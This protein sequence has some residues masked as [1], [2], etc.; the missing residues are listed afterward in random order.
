VAQAI[1]GLKAF[2]S[3]HPADQLNAT[4]PRRIG[5]VRER[6]EIRV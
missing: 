3:R 6:K 4:N 1:V 5:S 2:G